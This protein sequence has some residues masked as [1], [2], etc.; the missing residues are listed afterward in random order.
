M[1]KTAIVLF[2]TLLV[3]GCAAPGAYRKAGISPRVEEVSVSGSKYVRAKEAADAY[4]A[5]WYWDSTM[6][7]FTMTKSSSQAKVMVGS[8]LADLNGR[9]VNLKK[10]TEI[11]NGELL[12]SADFISK[13]AGACFLSDVCEKKV[14]KSAA[15]KTIASKGKPCIDTIVVDAGHGGKDPGAI[16]RDGTYEKNVVLNVAKRLKKHLASRGINVI[17]TRDTDTFI[18][19]GGRTEKANSNKAKLFVSIHANAN[20]Y[21]SINGF[22]VYYFSEATDDDARALAAAEN[23]ALDKENGNLVN[24]TTNLKAIIWDL[25]Y[26][27]YRAQSIRLARSISRYIND[28]LSIRNRGIKSARFYVLK[29]TRMPAVLVETAYLSN[30]YDEKKLAD[31]SFREDIALAISKGVLSYCDEYERREGYTN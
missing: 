14:G 10:D 11:H 27:E 24:P 17:M 21:R 23:A 18:S 15:I 12:I 16:G 7:I 19:L 4:A 13:V 22:E 6:K 9:I 25:K 31:S 29:N 30:Q 1:Q 20:K 5:D 26:S 8:S 2:I 3:S 28:D